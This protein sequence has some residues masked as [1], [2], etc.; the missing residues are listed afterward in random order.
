MRAH[1]EGCNEAARSSQA[2]PGVQKGNSNEQH[3]SNK[4]TRYAAPTYRPACRPAR[5]AYSSHTSATAPLG[6]RMRRKRHSR[7]NRARNVLVA[8]VAIAGLLLVSGLTN[9]LVGLIEPNAAATFLQFDEDEGTWS[10]V[11]VNASNPL[12]DGF[13][14]DTAD[15]GGGHS[16]DKRTRAGAAVDINDEE[17]D[18]GM[19]AWLAS[20]AHQY[21]FIL[22]YPLDKVDVTGISNEPRHYRYVGKRT[23]GEIFQTGETLEEYLA[24]TRMK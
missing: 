6:T 11:L 20:N 15:V 9:R 12:P 10:L 4:R 21:G 23:A 24:R 2:L 8:I 5:R 17:D 16:V 22:R 19:Y 1:T 7:F 13:S 3:Y 14:V 18:E